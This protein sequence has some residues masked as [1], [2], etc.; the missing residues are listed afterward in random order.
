MSVQTVKYVP[1]K[2][3]KCKEEFSRAS[4]SKRN[5]CLKCYHEHRNQLNADWKGKNIRKRGRSGPDGDGNYQRLM[6]D[7][8]RIKPIPTIDKED[9]S[10]EHEPSIDELDPADLSIDED[11][12]EEPI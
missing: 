5:L 2:C 6:T 1:A 3:S 10:E 11:L 4:F 12:S 9:G 8:L 7:Y